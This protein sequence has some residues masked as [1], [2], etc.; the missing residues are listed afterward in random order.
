MQRLLEHALEPRA[1][2]LFAA[3]CH[4]VAP[5]PDVSGGMIFF[6]VFLISKVRLHQS[7]SNRLFG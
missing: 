5:L 2:R 4:L 3:R 6:R 7:Q 1:P